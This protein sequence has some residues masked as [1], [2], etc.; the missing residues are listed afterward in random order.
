MIFFNFCDLK[1][2][3]KGKAPV[4]AAPK[5]VP[6]IVERAAPKYP[7]RIPGKPIPARKSSKSSGQ[8]TVT[9]APEKVVVKETA[10]PAKAKQ[11]A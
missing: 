9:R 11:S 6:E 4:K 10:K 2:K 5:Y 8:K 1:N 7:D 3:G